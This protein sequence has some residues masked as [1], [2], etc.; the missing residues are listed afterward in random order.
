M[1]GPFTT[2]VAFS[3]PFENEPDR[4]NGFVSDNTQE[5]IEEA[6]DTAH[7]IA[8]RAMPVC[9]F[10]G[11]AVIN[12]WLE[13]HHSQ[14]S[15]TSPLVIA[16]PSIV[17]A[18]SVSVRGNDTVTFTVYKNGTAFDTLVITAAHKARKKNLNYTLTD[19][20]DLSVQVTSG[21]CR[22]PTFTWSIQ[23]I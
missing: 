23:T 1:A 11:V 8:S 18:L 5:A 2:S 6:R 12:R 15:N 17:K 16:E 19:L 10:N 21:S 4:S 9:G 22:E 20:D 14:P 7:G 13:F 3:T